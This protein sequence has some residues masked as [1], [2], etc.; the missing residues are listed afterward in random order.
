M[1]LAPMLEGMYADPGIISCAP[2]LTSQ[3]AAIQGL[4]IVIY[5]CL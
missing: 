2:S 3:N 4:G 5:I 1:P